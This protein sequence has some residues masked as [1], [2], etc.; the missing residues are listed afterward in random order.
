MFY[1]ITSRAARWRKNELG[2]WAVSA[3]APRVETAAFRRVTRTF[4]AIKSV[5]NNINS[6]GGGHDSQRPSDVQLRSRRDRGC[7]PRDGALVFAERDRAAR[8]RNRPQQ[9][10]PTGSLAQDWIARPARH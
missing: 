2:D 6:P 3:P 1:P 4:P 10:I 7:D 5:S 8:R 9:S